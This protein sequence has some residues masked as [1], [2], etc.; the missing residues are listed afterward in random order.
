MRTWCSHTKKMAGL[1]LEWDWAFWILNFISFGP[2]IDFSGTHL[3]LWF[4]SSNCLFLTTP[5]RCLKTP[6]DNI[7]I[8]NCLL[9][10]SDLT[11]LSWCPKICQLKG[12]NLSGV[13][14]TDF[15]RAPFKFYSESCRHSGRAGLKPVWDHGRMSLTAFLPALSL[16]IRVR[17]HH[18]WK[19]LLHGCP[20]E[21]PASYWQAP[22]FKSR[23]S[24]RPPGE[25]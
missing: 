24:I 21:S 22:W 19:P 5:P 7:S 16:L 17:H 9:T 18:V 10:E 4:P 12:L 13:T 1:G 3:P 23:A 8:T 20:G 6:L 2:I 14:L 15:S 11:H 25:L